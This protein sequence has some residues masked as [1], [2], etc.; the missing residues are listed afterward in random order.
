[1]SSD[2]DFSKETA[3][4]PAPAERV[5]LGRSRSERLVDQDRLSEAR[6]KQSSDQPPVELAPAPAGDECFMISSVKGPKAF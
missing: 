4:V 6:P 2:W 3:L 5:A 1:M